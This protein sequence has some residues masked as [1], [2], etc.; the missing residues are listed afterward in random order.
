MMVSYIGTARRLPLLQHLTS[1]GVCYTFS[2]LAYLLLG[3]I[4]TFLAFS[5][6][7]QENCNLYPSQQNLLQGSFPCLDDF[8]S[9]FPCLDDVHSRFPCLDIFHSP[10]P[11]LKMIFIVH[12]LALM[13][14]M[15][16]SLASR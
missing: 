11:C 2:I 16:H 1:W 7:K 12:F 6:V 10:F 5:K 13:I 8:N 15:A 3:F 9:Q 14:F 4:E